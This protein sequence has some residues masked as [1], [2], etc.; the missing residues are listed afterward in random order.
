M[1]HWGYASPAFHNSN[2]GSET[3]KRNLCLYSSSPPADDPTFDRAG[4]HPGYGAREEA[5][6]HGAAGVFCTH[7]FCLEC[8]TRLMASPPAGRDHLAD[9]IVCPPHRVTTNCEVLCQL[10]RHQQREEPV[11]LEGNKLCCKVGSDGPTARCVCID[12]DVAPAPTQALLGRPCPY[13]NR[14]TFFYVVVLVLIPTIQLLLEHFCV[15]PRDLQ[16]F[17]HER[18]N[19]GTL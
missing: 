11:W 19:N 18:G 4:E 7:T 10:P 17:T 5:V 6:S 2:V 12:V 3:H 14:F 15:S 8:L 9:H 1:A 16:A 13:I